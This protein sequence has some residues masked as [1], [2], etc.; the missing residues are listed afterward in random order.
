MTA[1][2][3][4]IGIPTLLRERT[5]AKYLVA[6]LTSLWDNAS[7]VER[8]RISIVVMLANEITSKRQEVRRAVERA[9]AAQLASGWLR[10]VRAPSS[11]YPRFERG[12]NAFKDGSE[13]VHWRQKQCVDYAFLM[14]YCHSVAA[15]DA[16]LY[17]QLEDD[18]TTVQG[19]VPAVFEF[20]REQESEHLEQK[21]E[22]KQSEKQGKGEE[23]EK[24]IS[25]KKKGRGRKSGGESNED[26][27]P[28]GKE[29]HHEQQW[30]VLEYS[31]MGFIG[32][33]YAIGELPRVAAFFWLFHAEQPVDFLLR[34][35]LALLGVR[36]N[37]ARVRKPTLFHHVGLVSSLKGKR[38]GLQDT[39]E[40]GAAEHKQHNGDNPPARVTSSMAAFDTFYVANAYSRAPGAF[41]A[42]RVTAGDTITVRFD[43]PQALQRF[44]VET[45]AAVKGAKGE[46][47]ILRSGVVELQR[48]GGSHDGHS[49]K[50]T[51]ENGQWEAAGIFAGGRAEGE[52]D[53]E[54]VASDTHGAEE[55]E[56]V[57]GKIDTRIT[58]L[59][60]RVIKA[61]NSWLMVREV[62]VWT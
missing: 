30:V 44:A 46:H 1:G 41:W 26:Q 54:G 37:S 38:Q 15:N 20:V 59:R 32:K 40:A 35:H 49:S 21:G 58:A 61:Q 7:P 39:M 24:T 60:I 31:S 5:G 55:Q 8:D 42:T 12:R 2:D 29:G 53:V 36:D 6:T 43:T 45:G 13:R 17:L 34:Y 50:I 19:W 56:G 14:A 9:F 62:A 22:Q 47:D 11:F 23:E 4:I 10:L 28:L 18:V 27:P 48:V 16:R 57:T 51:S 52:I 3:L 25:R 33:L